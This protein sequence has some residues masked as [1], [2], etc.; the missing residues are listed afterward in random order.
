[1]GRGGYRAR[2]ETRDTF[3]QK[4]SATCSVTSVRPLWNFHNSYHHNAAI[5]GTCSIRQYL[6]VD[7]VQLTLPFGILEFDNSSTM[8]FSISKNSLHRGMNIRYWLF[9]RINISML[10][11]G[12]CL[13]LYTLE[14]AAHL[15]SDTFLKLAK[16][17]L[18]SIY[19]SFFAL[20]LYQFPG[21]CRESG[22]CITTSA[23]SIA[24]P[25]AR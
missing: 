16:R 18:P 4:V 19:I 17:K 23:K 1:M 10:L 15:Y 13:T 20:R 7:C 14:S 6:R 9:L 11:F 3:W 25:T 12:L 8:D 24:S 5:Y 2:D 22:C 21:K